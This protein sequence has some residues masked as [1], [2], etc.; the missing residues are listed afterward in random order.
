[1]GE[2]DGVWW[3]GDGVWWEGDGVKGR[4]WWEGWWEGGQ[5]EVGGGVV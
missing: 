4:E 2:G 3:E 5:C 1:M